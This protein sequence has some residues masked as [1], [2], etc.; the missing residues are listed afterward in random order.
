MT[1]IVF[2][3]LVK[4]ANI[5]VLHFTWHK[6]SHFTDILGSKSVTLDIILVGIFV[7]STSGVIDYGYSHLYVCLRWP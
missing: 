4:S 7:A 5:K 3:C 1:Y 2:L 6:K